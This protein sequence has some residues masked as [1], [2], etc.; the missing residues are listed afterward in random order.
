MQ[1][2]VGDQLLALVRQRPD[3][4]ILL[5]AAAPQQIQCDVAQLVRVVG[6]IQQH[7][8]AAL[9]KPLIVF[10]HPKHI[11]PLLLGVPIPAYPLKH[12]SAVM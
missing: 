6:N 4:Q 10:A 9:Q 7:N 5:I 11:Q 12:R 1:L 3:V 8:L 2:Q